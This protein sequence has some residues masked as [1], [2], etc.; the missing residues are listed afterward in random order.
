M[1]IE[2]GL[3]AGT[4]IPASAL[5]PIYGAD[6]LPVIDQSTGDARLVWPAILRT[7]I[8]LEKFSPFEGW[9][10]DVTS[11]ASEYPA[12]DRRPDQ[13]GNSVQ[14][15]T[16]LYTAKLLKDDKLFASA[17]VLVP[18]FSTWAVTFG[19]ELARGALY[20]AL[21]LSLPGVSTASDPDA[22]RVTEGD[23]GTSTTPKAEASNELPPAAVVV[24]VRS[25]K[26]QAK[27]APV[28]PVPTENRT[29]G[30]R[31]TDPNG[32]DANLRS[33]IEK[34]CTERSIEVPELT[35]NKQARAVLLQL[36]ASNGKEAQA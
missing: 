13:Y 6:G 35:D 27:P 31:G 1:K 11:V 2:T 14:Q 10:V 8:F 3:F 18:V 5:R 30:P 36:L 28:T 26:P 22:A 34:V 29:G 33:N 15:P 24:P 20:D 21:G 25:A 32:V 23:K 7:P 12:W 4:E 9:A 19:E 17:T 16:R